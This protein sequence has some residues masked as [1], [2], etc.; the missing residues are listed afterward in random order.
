MRDCAR[1][2]RFEDYQEKYGTDKQS[3]TESVNKKYAEVSALLAD[4]KAIEK[5]LADEETE[6]K[7]NRAWLQQRIGTLARAIEDAEEAGNRLIEQ[8]KTA[9][10]YRE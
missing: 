7:S 1:R 10:R 9:C 3:K 4:I 5:E 6:L 8:R 2:R